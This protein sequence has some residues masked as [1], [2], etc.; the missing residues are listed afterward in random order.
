[1]AQGLQNRPLPLP[2]AGEE[3]D[4]IRGTS[5]PWPVEGLVG[6]PRGRAARCQV[7]ESSCP[8]GQGPARQWSLSGMREDVHSKQE[9]IQW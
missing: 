1:M 9:F 7:A 6:D 4:Q 2:S 3:A 5:P 8:P